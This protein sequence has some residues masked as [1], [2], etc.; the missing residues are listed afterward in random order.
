[1]IFQQVIANDN[2]ITEEQFSHPEVTNLNEMEKSHVSKNPTLDV[3]SEVEPHSYNA[4]R[5]NYSNP[6]QQVTIS[7]SR[8]YVNS[9]HDGQINQGYVGN[10]QSS[11]NRDGSTP[12]VRGY[13]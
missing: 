3:I 4:Q 5:S 13:V 1:M 10:S 11:L 8:I 12:S 2:E 7:D 6:K 9:T